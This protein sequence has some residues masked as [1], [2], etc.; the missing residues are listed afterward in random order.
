MGRIVNMAS[1][2]ANRPTCF[3]VG[4]S[5]TKAAIR[6]FTRELALELTRDGVTVNA[7]TL[8][9]CRIEFKTGRAQWGMTAPREVYNP[10]LRGVSRVVEPADVGE[11]ILFLCSEKAAAITGDCIRIDRGLILA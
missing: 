10:A 2:H 4:Y 3:D 7:I 11:A 8:G 5:M 1:I 6:M 9:A